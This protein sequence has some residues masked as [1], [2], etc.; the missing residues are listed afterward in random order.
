MSFLVRSASLRLLLGVAV[1]AGLVVLAGARPATKR[2]PS[3]KERAEADARRVDGAIEAFG[4][5]RAEEVRAVLESLPAERIPRGREDDVAY[6]RAM[7]TEDGGELTAALAEYLK[8][9]PKGKYRRAVTLALGRIHYVQGEYSEAEN[10][11]SVFSPGI[12]K[13]FVGRQALVQRGLA[14]LARGDAAGALQFLNSAKDDLADSPQEE[15]Y[16][17]A[18]SQAAL[19]ASRPS[20]AAEALRRLLERH[21]RGEYAPQALYALGTTLEAVGRAGDATGVFRQVMSRYPNSYEAT[22]V[23]DRGIRP[24]TASAPVSPLPLGGGF[25][26][27][28]GAFSRRDIAD[29]LAEDLKRAGVE[30]VSVKQGSETPPIYRVRAGA[31]GTRDEAR[32]LGERLRRERGFSYTVVSRGGS[33]WNRRRCSSSTAASRPNTRAA[34]SSSVW[35]IS[36]RRSGRTP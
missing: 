10:V 31:F 7:L 12:E 8:A 6:L 11:L 28:V 18:L 21:P 1:A 26:V 34:S 27:Q 36:T 23:R 33:R 19:R 25:A 30:E 35:A 24:V 9:Y 5:G 3:A 16:L 17:F 2:P 29:A 22:R 14:Q 4:Q 32:A 15:S 13:D 20:Q